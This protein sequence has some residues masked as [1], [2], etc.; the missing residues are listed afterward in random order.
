M[1]DAMISLKSMFVSLEYCIVWNCATW[2]LSIVLLHLILSPLEAPQVLKL[3]SKYTLAGF[4]KDCVVCTGT[5]DSIAAFLAARA[6]EPGKAVSTQL[7]L[8]F[9]YIV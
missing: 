8:A 2:I 6:T 7:D 5:T 1:D 9:L 3:C 4:P